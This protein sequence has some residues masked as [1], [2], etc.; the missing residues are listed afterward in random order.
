MK[1]HVGEYIVIVSSKF[2][3]MH[4]NF[5]VSYKVR[6]KVEDVLPPPPPPEALGERVRF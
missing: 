6:V 3:S 4:M 2:E 5:S 1:Q